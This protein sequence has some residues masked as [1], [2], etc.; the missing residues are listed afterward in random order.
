MLPFSESKGNIWT[1]YFSQSPQLK[2]FVRDASSLIHTYS[3]MFAL[4]LLNSNSTEKETQTILKSKNKLLEVLGTI[5]SGEN[6][7]GQTI[8]AVQIDNLNRMSNAFN[9]NTLAFNKLLV[10]DVNKLTG[11]TLRASSLQSCKEGPSGGNDTVTL[12]PVSYDQNRLKKEFIVIAHNPQMT[13][14][15]NSFVSIKLP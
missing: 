7:A 2:S 14:R 1:G 12:C 15:K 3:K 8:F 4:K 9:N 6:I 11:L 10:D 13:S 5:N